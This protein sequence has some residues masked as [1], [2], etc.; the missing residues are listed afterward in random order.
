MMSQK[1]E[2]KL[3][4]NPVAITF[5]WNSKLDL[6]NYGFAAKLII[7]GLKGYLIKDDNKRYIKSITH[8]YSDE[9]TI[10]ISIKELETNQ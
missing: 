6:D 2:K 7:D 5:S 10:K 8:Q 3:F 4:Q 1:I 9:D